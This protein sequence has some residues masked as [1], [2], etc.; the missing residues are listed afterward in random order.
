MRI[1]LTVISNTI[2]NA[3]TILNQEINKQILKY[4]YHSDFVQ[5]TMIQI[6]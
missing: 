3:A 6:S 5:I 2:R 4:K 1:Y